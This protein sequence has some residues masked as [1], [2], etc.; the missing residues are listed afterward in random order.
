MAGLAY[1]DYARPTAVRLL[2]A[3]VLEQREVAPGCFFLRMDLPA[4]AASIGAGQFLHIKPAGDE[5]PL[6]R[7]PFSVYD[8]PDDPKGAVDL[9]YVVVGSGTKVL[10]ELRAGDTVSVLGPLGNTFDYANDGALHV[11]VAGGIGVAPMPDLAKH[12]IAAGC[13]PATDLHAVI[14]ARTA[15]MLY[16]REDFE[17]LG[18]PCDTATDDGSHG[19]HGNAV[20]RTAQLLDAVAGVDSGRTVRIYGC[21]PEPMLRALQALCNERNIRGQLSIDRRMACGL[22]ICRSCI[23]GVGPSAEDCHF[24]TVCREGPIF[25]TATLQW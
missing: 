20:Q 17:R 23:V 16:C 22:G 6:L 13:D 1:S 9:L 15:S 25:E 14:G 19:F 18:V 3:P 21:G 5:T 8:I 7:R 12:C 11:L 4:I 24:E 2:D 10:S